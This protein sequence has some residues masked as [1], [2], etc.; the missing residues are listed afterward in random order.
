MKDIKQFENIT[1]KWHPI[2]L[3]LSLVSIYRFIIHRHVA[4]H[5]VGF[6]IS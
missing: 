2:D 4:F 5:I 6:D 3:Q 1:A